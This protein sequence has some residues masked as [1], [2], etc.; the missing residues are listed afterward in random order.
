MSTHCKACDTSLGSAP[1]DPELCAECLEVVV[2]YN[3]DV[4][5]RLTDEEMDDVATL[6]N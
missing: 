6:D 1:I 3:R 5:D 2:D 4:I